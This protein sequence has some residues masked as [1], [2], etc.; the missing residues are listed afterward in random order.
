MASSSESK[1]TKLGMMY[2]GIPSEYP[3]FRLKVD[4]KA[5]ALGIATKIESDLA[6]GALTMPGWSDDDKK[7]GANLYN[8]IIQSLKEKAVNYANTA[9]HKNLVGLIF[10][11]KKRTFPQSKGARK[12]VIERWLSNSQGDAESITDFVT[13]Q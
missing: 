4:T 7:Q 1:D 5:A 13:K 3:E 6:A 10:Q 2:S 8:I 12:T 9:P 11:L